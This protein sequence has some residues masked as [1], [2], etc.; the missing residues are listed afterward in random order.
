M[1]EGARP[2]SWRGV[3]L[4]CVTQSCVWSEIDRRDS[5]GAEEHRPT[6]W[7]NKSTF[8]LPSGRPAGSAVTPGPEIQG[9]EPSAYLQPPDLLLSLGGVPPRCPVGDVCQQVK[10]QLFSNYEEQG[11]CLEQQLQELSRVLERSSSLSTELQEVSTTLSVINTGL[12]HSS[13][14]HPDQPSPLDTTDP[15]YGEP[16]P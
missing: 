2:S 16:G 4:R 7:K 8:L 1:P 12:L 10:E 11:Q 13:R 5:R 6:H 15:L 14:D 3:S 9:G